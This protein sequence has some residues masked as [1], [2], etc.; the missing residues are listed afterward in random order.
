MMTFIKATIAIAGLFFLVATA[1]G[2][3]ACCSYGCCDCSCV[4]VKAQAKAAN[5]S[6]ALGRHGTLQ[7]FTINASDQ[8]PAPGSFKC[9]T[10]AEV[11]VCNRQ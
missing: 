2:Y 9:S 3:A 6:K 5:L 4:G 7:S 10:Q 11:A 8:K 1:P